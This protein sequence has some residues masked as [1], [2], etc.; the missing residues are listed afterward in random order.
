MKLFGLTSILYIPAKPVKGFLSLLTGDLQYNLA[1]SQVIISGT[2]LS[3]SQS[4]VHVQERPI[5]R[6]L[7]HRW[8]AIMMVPITCIAPVAAFI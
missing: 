4:V 1:S 7:R 3:L 2:H 8:F 5:R 6:K